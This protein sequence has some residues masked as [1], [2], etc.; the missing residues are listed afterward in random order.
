MKNLLSLVALTVVLLIL[1]SACEW[2]E[3]TI[4]YQDKER[5]ISAVEEII[6]DQ[7]EAENPDLDLEVNIFE[8]TED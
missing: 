3:E 1:L 8:E 6:A 4:I 7:L 5:P 2:E